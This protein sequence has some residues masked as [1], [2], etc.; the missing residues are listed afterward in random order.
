VP[1]YRLYAASKLLR[2]DKSRVWLQGEAQAGSKR[3]I[4]P[5][6]VLEMRGDPKTFA[7]SLELV[8]IGTAGIPF[9]DETTIGKP[10]KHY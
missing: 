5:P 9:P 7:A 3:S 6:L 2:C 10:A 8:Q 1:E 4:R